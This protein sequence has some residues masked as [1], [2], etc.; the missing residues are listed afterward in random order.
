LQLTTIGKIIDANWNN[1]PSG[2]E[3]IEIDEYIIMPNHFH[4][5]IMINCHTKAIPGI[6]ATARVAP[7]LGNIIGAF[8]SRC[9]TDYL[10]H[11]R[12]NNVNVIG[13][14]WQRNYYEHI[15]RNKRELHEIR[16]YIQNNPLTWDD[17]ENN[18]DKEI[19]Q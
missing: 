13:K 18:P 16:E 8:K 12:E 11:I 2:Y 10:N 19:P 15:I 7:T 3:N 17:D 14:I 5:I 9:V 6:R 4:G 1:I